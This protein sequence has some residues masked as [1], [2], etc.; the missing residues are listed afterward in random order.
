MRINWYNGAINAAKRIARYLDANF[1]MASVRKFNSLIKEYEI[2]LLQNPLIGLV[3]P[4]LQDRSVVYHSIVINRYNKLI[5]Y[6]DSDFIYIVDIWDTRRNPDSLS[7]R[8]N[9]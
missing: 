3:E 6:V 1:G 8:I 5:Y 7:D 2:V 9:P 4:L